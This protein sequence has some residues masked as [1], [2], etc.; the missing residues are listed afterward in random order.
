MSLLELLNL[1]KAYPLGYTYFRPRLHKAFMSQAGLKDEGK[2]RE[3][4]KR[5]EFVKK[6]VSTIFIM[7]EYQGR[8]S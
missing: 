5:A 3:A 7:F 4:I 6:G 8:S 1:G 2:I